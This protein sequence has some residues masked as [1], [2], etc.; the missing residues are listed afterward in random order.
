MQVNAPDR[1]QLRTLAELRLDRPVV[2]SLY[3]NLDPSEFATP[4]ARKTSVRSLI[5]AAERRLR[6]QNGLEQDDRAD[7]AQH[8]LLDEVTQ[9]QSLA[10]VLPCDRDHQTQVGVDHPLLGREIAALDALGELDLIGSGQQRVPARFVEEELEG[11]LELRRSG[12]AR[13]RRLRRTDQL[14]SGRRDSFALIVRNLS[15]V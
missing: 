10:L 3:L 2:L 5:D 4:P 8:A 9:G 7:Q 15:K 14:I 13:L 11:I 12:L 6:E 1:D